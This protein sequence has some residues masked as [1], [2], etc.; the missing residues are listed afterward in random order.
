M[1]HTLFFTLAVVLTISIAAQDNEHKTT[2]NE[3]QTIFGNGDLKISGFGAPIMNF[4]YIEKDF[5]YMI[6]GGAGVIINNLFFGAY[7]MGAINELNL[8]DDN[9]S[10]IEFAHGGLW[11]GYTM[12]HNKAIHP[13]FHTRIGWG[14]IYQYTAVDNF[15]YDPSTSDHFFIL[16]PTAEVEVNLSRF[17]KLGIGSTYDFIFNVQS[18]YETGDFTHPSLFI[19]FKFGWF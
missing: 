3:Y 7:G 15:V 11:L 6:G 2:D 5:A 9:N 14:T 1:K 10:S 18:P 17:F 16:S 8:K 12:F 13:V 4:T 19:S